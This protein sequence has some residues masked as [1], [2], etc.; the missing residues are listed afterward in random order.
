SVRQ[1]HDYGI[2]GGEIGEPRPGPVGMADVPAAIHGKESQKVRTW[3][4]APP[5][6]ELEFH[7]RT[8]EARC[9]N[10]AQQ[11]DDGADAADEHIGEAPN[12]T[13]DKTAAVDV[14]SNGQWRT[15]PQ[16]RVAQLVGGDRRPLLCDCAKSHVTDIKSDGVSI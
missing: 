12:L 6:H 13:P 1:S 2:G 14:C 7:E 3:P 16:I 9:S 8:I 5:A 10:R 4:A 11:A 15:H